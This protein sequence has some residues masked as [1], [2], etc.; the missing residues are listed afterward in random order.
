MF[1]AKLAAI[2]TRPYAKGRDVY[3]LFW[4]RTKWKE[5]LPNFVLLNNALAQKQKDFKKV[6]EDNW[7]E[8]TREKIQSL[9]WRD[10]ENDIIPFLELRDDLHAFTQENL[11]LLVSL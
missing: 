4:Y 10:I 9:K 7:L 6:N 1:A 8:V 5:L 2:F 11:L 3:D